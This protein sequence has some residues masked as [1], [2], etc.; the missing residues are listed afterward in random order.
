MDALL[1]GLVDDFKAAGA[2]ELVTGLST[3]IEM[4]GYDPFPQRDLGFSS[5]GLS[6]PLLELCIRRRVRAI[7]NIS[8][9]QNSIVERLLHD[10][11]VVTGVALRDGRRLSADF[12]TDASRRGI[13]G[14]F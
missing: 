2:V 14:Q 8:W 4:P 11:G 7:A 12:V 5:Y 1:P 13:Y 10:A 9:E 3:R 6:R